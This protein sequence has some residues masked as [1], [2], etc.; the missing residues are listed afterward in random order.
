MHFGSV[1]DFYRVILNRILFIQPRDIETKMLTVIITTTVVTFLDRFMIVIF[2]VVETSIFAFVRYIPPIST[3]CQP[4]LLRIVSI[5]TTPFLKKYPTITGATIIFISWWWH[6]LILAITDVHRSE[7]TAKPNFS[8]SE[9]KGGL[10]PILGQCVQALS[11]RWMK[12]DKQRAHSWSSIRCSF[13]LPSSSARP[14]RD[15]ARSG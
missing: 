5:V 10:L 12:A 15:D 14:G 2:C 1:V 7:E 4:S 13:F 6:K 9:T 3:H 8:H 11:W